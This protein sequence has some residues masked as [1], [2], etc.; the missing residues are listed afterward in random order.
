MILN[1]KDIFRGTKNLW[2][3]S[4]LLE[5]ILLTARC[6]TGLWMDAVR[7]SVQDEVLLERIHDAISNLAGRLR[8]QDFAI[9]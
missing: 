4:Q 9:S 2:W 7:L 6:S 5:E 8:K 3:N 1:R